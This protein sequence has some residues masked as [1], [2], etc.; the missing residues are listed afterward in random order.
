MTLEQEIIILQ[1]IAEIKHKN[2]SIEEA[3]M[4]ILPVIIGVLPE[5][6]QRAYNGM[7]SDIIPL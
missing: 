7:I 4:L 3:N 6:I 1:K 5:D 2:V